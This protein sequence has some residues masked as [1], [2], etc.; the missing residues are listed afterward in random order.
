M[1]LDIIKSDIPLMAKKQWNKIPK[2]I[3]NAV[4]IPADLPYKET[5][6]TTTAVSGPGLVRAIKWAAADQINIV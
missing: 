4:L 3:P 1:L 5:C 6:L 2:P